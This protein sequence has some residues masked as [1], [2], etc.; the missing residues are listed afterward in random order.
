[1]TTT[2]PVEAADVAPAPPCAACGSA[3]TSDVRFVVW[4]QSCG[5]NAH[6][7]ATA[8]KGRGDRF[9]R[10]LNR[11]AEERLYQRIARHGTAR[12]APDAASI[13]AYALSGLVHLVTVALVCAGVAMVLVPHIMF[14]LLGAFLLLLAYGLRPRLGPGRKALARRRVLARDAAPAL[15]ALCARIAD[16]L[17]TTAPHEIV[18][19]GH[20]NASY[21]RIGLRRQVVLTLGL[22]LWE[23][24]TPAEQLAI[25]G[26]ELGHGANGDSRRG[27][28][29]SSALDSLEEWYQMFR[30]GV[31]MQRRHDMT[32][33]TGVRGQAS[34]GGL[35]WL[36]EMFALA[37]MAVFA[38]IT[39]LLYRLLSRLTTLSGRRAE[40]LADE[41][42]ARIA[43][44][45]A[46]AALLQALPLG[47]SARYVQ[48]Q[49]G[50]RGRPVTRDR[51]SGR[52]LDR[53]AQPD[54]WTD[55]RSYVHSIP[56]S[57]RARRILVSQ[58]D[59][60]AVDATHPPTHLRL[61]HVRQLP[62]A[63]PAIVLTAAE[64][65]AIEAELAPARDAIARDLP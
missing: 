2:T 3:L 22:P 51:R 63:E 4:C 34:G 57:E 39:L 15:H 50:L 19:D 1:M 46:A 5:W 13:A 28:W 38:E 18:V 29:I 6:P 8:A 33:R 30:P 25:L 47:S 60:S 59:D 64:R 32:R 62:P 48:Q 26:H 16:E 43:G 45:E 65:A 54:F 61:A 55:L 41:M 31:A 37:V 7:G 40:Y 53:A 36:G 20:Y 17:G 23:T 12:S 24:V 52:L 42:A 11:A 35:A 49:R 14:Q 27:L 21:S 44:P 56:E 58:L 9:Q 10:K